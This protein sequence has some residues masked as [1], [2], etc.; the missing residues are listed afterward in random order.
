MATYRAALLALS[1]GF[2]AACGAA[3]EE[4]VS[5]DAADVGTAKALIEI[6]AL[7]IWSQPLPLAGMKLSVKRD[8]RPIQ[9]NA[10]QT[11][12]LYVQRAGKYE[13]HLE[14]PFHEPIDL[15]VDYDGSSAPSGANV[16]EVPKGQGIAFGHTMRNTGARSLQTHALYIGLRHKFFS[17]EG[18]PARR[19][20]DVKMMMDGEE[21]WGTIHGDLKRATKSVMLSTWWW[22]SDFELVRSN[23]T[24]LTEDQRWPNTILGTI[25]KT[26]ATKR[27]L[28][29]QFWGQDSI[30]SWMTTDSKLRKLASTP[31]DRFEMMGQ[32]NPSQGRFKMAVPDFSFGARVTAAHED[33]PRELAVDAKVASTVPEHDVDIRQLGISIDGASYHQ[34]FGV[35]DDKVAYIGGMNFR[36]TDWDSSEHKVYDARRMAFDASASARNDVAA[37]EETPDNGPRKDYIV[38]IEGPSA[39]DAADV[40]KKRWD[41]QIKDR[42]SNSENST[43]FEVMRDIPERADGMQVQVTTTLPQPFWEHSIAETWFNAVRQ[44]EKM[45]F[46]EDQYFRMPMINATIIERMREKPS[47]KLVVITKPVTTSDPGCVQTY[48]SDLELRSAFRDRYLTV[49]L[50]SFDGVTKEFADIDVHSKMLIVDDVFMSVGSANKNNRGIVYEGE[51]NVAIV[52]ARVGDMR[53]RIA[54]NILGEPADDLE[55]FWTKLGAAAR[56]NDA[57]YTA[58]RQPKG[59]AFSLAFGDPGRCLLWR[60][61][62]DDT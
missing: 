59:F 22:E 6:H 20:N 30:L 1:V 61:G 23:N 11:T 35:I 10:E 27:V 37:R 9:V 13:I 26:P 57:A 45:I 17:A 25:E 40:F 7:D 21:A 53:R 34:K 39:Q 2:L 18:R 19:G 62:P 46:I 52:D 15:A 38:R 8:G 43:R 16:P 36:P 24:S 29:G 12:N 3:P 54:Q 50:R 48:K 60:M 28:V 41:N 42:V 44:A 56:A 32:A 47:L 49:E 4:D 33:A 51:M 55:T 14:A 31:N 58:K 5:E